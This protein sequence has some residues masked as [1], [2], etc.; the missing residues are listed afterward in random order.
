M[1]TPQT[2][3][4]G[5]HLDREIFRAVLPP[6]DYRIGREGEVEI[7][8][9]WKNVSRKHGTLTLNYFDWIIEDAGSANG[10]SV[11]G[12]LITEA[13]MIFPGQEVK[14]GDVE[15]KL[16]RLNIED[17][18]E[19]LA[20][21]TA[22]LSRFL[23]EELRGLKKYKV[24]GIIGMG[25]MGAVLEAEDLATRRRVA[26]KVLLHV[27]SPED[28]AR[29]IEEAQVT[30]QLEH[31]N[32]VPI[33][34]LNVNE[35]DKP[36]YV[37]KLVRGKSLNHTLH[38]IKLENVAALEQFSLVELLTIF[39]KI[40]DAVRYAHSKGVIHR[41][42]KPDNIML[43]EFGEVLVMDWGL[44]KPLGRSAHT[45]PE[46]TTLRTM[47]KSL[48]ADSPDA[49]ETM[50]RAVGTPQYMSPEQADGRSDIDGRTDIYSLG[51]ILYHM[52]TLS[53]P[54]SGTERDEIM[55]EVITGKII[56]PEEAI[57]EKRPRHL[58]DGKLPP[59]LTA[60]A[61]KAL[62]LNPSDRYATVRR[63]R[64]AVKYAQFD[65]LQ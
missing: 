45:R 56:P 2:E 4:V 22:A 60:I 63:L 44:A 9:P 55:D 23:P 31:P 17:A 29:F 42:L 53:P 39:L 6:G 8:L 47:V 26:M 58:L 37:M 49:I 34:E 30:A 1:I 43:G 12:K 16:R 7:L 62:S 65:E 14:V 54:F 11:G 15:L 59:A 32:I 61:L 51:A 57:R 48:R 5:I 25:G 18:N 27:G 41:D 19:S 50:A 52:L 24:H 36:F 33:H 35:L 20:P 3:V 13:A 40:C 46:E 21:Q 28:V 10:T 64:D 38:E